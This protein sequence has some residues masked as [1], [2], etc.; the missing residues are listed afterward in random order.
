MSSPRLALVVLLLAVTAL[1]LPAGAGAVGLQTYVSGVG[2][3]AYDCTLLQPCKTWAGAISKTTAGGTISAVDSGGFGSVTITKSVTLD[4]A[5]HLA[6]SLAASTQGIIVNG[7]G[8]NVVIKRL[9]IDATGICT[10]AT[11]PHGIRFLQGSSLTVQDVGIQGFR[12]AGISLEPTDGHG[13][14]VVRDSVITNNCTAGVQAASPALSGDMTVHLK[15]NLL[16]GNATGVRAGAHSAVTLTSNTIVANT[17]PT[18]T[19]A[20]GTLTSLGDNRIG[21]VTGTLGSMPAAPAPGPGP[22]P[23]TVPVPAPAPVVLPPVA[24]KPT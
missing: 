23:S 19:E 12:G 11:T 13:T 16:T 6:S 22:G 9:N 8:I 18:A 4:G 17:T 5:G 24:K 20:D 14:V 3:D 21:G 1:A 10:P 7:A 15:D 2:D